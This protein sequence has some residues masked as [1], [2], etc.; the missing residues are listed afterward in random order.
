MGS[1]RAACLSQAQALQGAM[2]S[3]PA[4]FLPSSQ[5]SAFLG[6]V[7]L[8]KDVYFRSSLL[9]ESGRTFRTQRVQVSQLDEG[10]TPADLPSKPLLFESTVSFYRTPEEPTAEPDAPATSAT[11][12]ALAPA[13]P[14]AETDS[15]AELGA[16]VKSGEVPRGAL[17]RTGLAM[18]AKLSEADMLMTIRVPREPQPPRGF[19]R[20]LYLVG[21]DPE[22]A[23][24]NRAILPYVRSVI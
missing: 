2:A 19:G 5:M 7:L 11:A 14:F 12:A 21:L 20:S 18:A 15:L 9:R 10:E 1:Y 22:L 24:G 3:T 17:Y 6:P 16:R 8:E 13:L 4:E 23:R